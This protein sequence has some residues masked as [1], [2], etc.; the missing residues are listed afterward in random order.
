VQCFDAQALRRVHE[1][2]GL[3]CS[4][5]LED[6]ADWRAALRAHGHWLHGLVAS[7]KLLRGFRPKTAA[8]SMP[9]MPAACVYTHGPF[10]TTASARVMPVSTRN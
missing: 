2:T 6:D 3:H 4:L 7:K 9:R 1:A 5:G 10:A 8:W